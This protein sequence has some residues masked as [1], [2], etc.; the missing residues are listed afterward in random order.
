MPGGEGGPGGGQRVRVEVIDSDVGQHDCRPVVAG[1]LLP[2]LVE[3]GE[4]EERC[5]PLRA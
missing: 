1:V 3:L 5:P 2:D 4:I